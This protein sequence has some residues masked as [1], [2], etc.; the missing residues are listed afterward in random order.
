[1]K[2]RSIEKP[3]LDVGGKKTQIAEKVKCIR[4]TKPTDKGQIKSSDLQIHIHMTDKYSALV[5]NDTE[6]MPLK[7][8]CQI[9]KVVYLSI[10]HR[11]LS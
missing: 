11:V 10:R 6:T 1:M 2:K 5:W 8:V 4:A 7:E 9:Q 3:I